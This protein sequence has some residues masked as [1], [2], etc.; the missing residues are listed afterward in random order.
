[1]VQLSHP[2]HPY[3]RGCNI[4][5]LIMKILNVEIK[6]KIDGIKYNEIKKFLESKSSNIIGL[7][8]QTDYYFK[9][10]AGKLKLRIG[11]VERS[12]IYY[13]RNEI[14]GLKSSNVLLFNISNDAEALLDILKA[15]QEMVNIVKK[16]REIYFIDNVKFHL[17]KVK[18]LGTFFEIEAISE[19]HTI[20]KEHL[21]QQCKSYK[22]RFEIKDEDLIDKSYADMVASI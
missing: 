7:D 10:D 17:D 6:A 1:M 14:K 9:T 8:N 5:I 3:G 18:D 15:S 21:E 12:L 2:G 13:Q 19:N 22:E 11:N 20:Q 16:K 4:Q